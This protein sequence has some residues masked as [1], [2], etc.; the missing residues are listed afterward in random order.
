MFAVF[1]QPRGHSAPGGTRAH[2]DEVIR[3]SVAWRR[4]EQPRDAPLHHDGQ[5]DVGT[6]DRVEEAKDEEVAQYRLH[7]ALSEHYALQTSFQVFMVLCYVLAV[8]V[9]VV[10]VVQLLSVVVF[11]VEIS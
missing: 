1:G 2:H 3:R 5:V 9:V 6:Q 10:V 7:V 11:L 4:K 8:D